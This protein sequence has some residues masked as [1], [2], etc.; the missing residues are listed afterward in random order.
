MSRTD[1]DVIVCSSALLISVADSNMMTSLSSNLKLIYLVDI[2]YDQI[3]NCLQK[4]SCCWSRWNSQKQNCKFQFVFL[5]V[6][7]LFSVCFF[8]FYLKSEGQLSD[9][10]RMARHNRSAMPFPGT[11][12]LSNT[13]P[14]SGF[15]PISFQPKS[16]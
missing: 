16:K 2:V 9:A 4:R 5:H 11:A 6:V 8:C 1:D 7:F 13:S 15:R 14:T 3:W 12:A 10:D